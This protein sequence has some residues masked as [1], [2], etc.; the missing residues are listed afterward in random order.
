R[1]YTDVIFAALRHELG[2]RAGELAK[3][4][5]RLDD[6]VYISEIAGGADLAGLARDT[7]RIDAGTVAVPLE[8]MPE[9]LALRSF[10]ADAVAF[11]KNVGLAH[12]LKRSQDVKELSA[13]VEY[14]FGKPLP[15][16][17]FDK[18]R[19]YRIAPGQATPSPLH[20]SAPPPATPQNALD[21]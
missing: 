19:L 21:T 2:R 18:S 3:L 8:Q 1:V 6:D 13:V 11:E 20:L 17:F 4:A 10:V 16:A 15:P 14:L 5:P 9:L 12:G 7:D